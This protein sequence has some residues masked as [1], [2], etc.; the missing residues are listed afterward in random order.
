M[1]FCI[2]DVLRL[3]KPL[4]GKCQ[5]SLNWTGV[6]IIANI[7]NRLNEW[8]K[9]P[10]ASATVL[11]RIDV[12]TLSNETFKSLIKSVNFMSDDK[13]DSCVKQIQKI[14]TIIKFITNENLNKLNMFVYT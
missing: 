10:I 4:F 12:Y 8:F 13:F 3:G 5:K 1:H 7:L 9:S 2:L 11:E 6:V 14:I